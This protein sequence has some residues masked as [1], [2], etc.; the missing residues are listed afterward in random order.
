MEKV[1]KKKQAPSKSYTLKSFG[2]N[3]RKLLELKLITKEDFEKLEEI[4]GKAVQTY[5]QTE[6]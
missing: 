1:E 3:N 4:K 6:F 2:E 5:M